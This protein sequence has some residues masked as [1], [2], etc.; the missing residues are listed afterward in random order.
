L[1]TEGAYCAF[2]FAVFKLYDPVRK[3]AMFNNNFQQA[4]GASS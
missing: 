1:L 3:F 4:V 2:I